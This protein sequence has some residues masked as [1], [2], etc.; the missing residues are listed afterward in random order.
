VVFAK[1]AVATCAMQKTPRSPILKCR[2]MIYNS[3]M[4]AKKLI[5]EVFKIQ[6][7]EEEEK[8]RRKKTTAKANAVN[9]APKLSVQTAHTAGIVTFGALIV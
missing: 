8:Y 7:S 4:T 2:T 1:R 3:K 5:F 9:L 6:L